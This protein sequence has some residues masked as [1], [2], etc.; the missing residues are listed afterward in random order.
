MARTPARLPN[1]ARIS[2]FVTLGVL[3]TTVPA[4]LIDGVLQETGRQSQRYR[5]LPAPLVVSHVMPLA[6]YPPA[7]YGEVL[8]W[9]LEGVRWLRLRGIDVAAASKSAITR[10]RTRLGVAPMKELYRRVARPLAVADTPGAWSRGRRLVSLNATLVHGGERDRSSPAFLL[11]HAART[12]SGRPRPSI[13]LSA[14]TAIWVST[15]WAGPAWE[16]R[17]SPM[18]RL[19]RLIAA[20]ALAL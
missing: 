7:S 16:R 11:S 13:R 8:R 15:C 2:D 5:L 10:A 14:L 6:L 3:T 9:L 12:E 20:S 18:T 19:N 1:G 17:V 4:E